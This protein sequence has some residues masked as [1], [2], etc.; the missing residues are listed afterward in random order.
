MKKK[1]HALMCM[2]V[3]QKSRMNEPRVTV[4]THEIHLYGGDPL[5]YWVRARTVKL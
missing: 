1:F 4:S 3:V 2:H 5:V